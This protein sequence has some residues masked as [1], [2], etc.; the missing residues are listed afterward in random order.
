[1]STRLT[2]LSILREERETRS[3]VEAREALAAGRELK[4]SRTSSCRENER[5]SETAGSAK[6][7]RGK[8]TH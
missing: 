5:V 6:S 1:M 7:V 2:C 4:A 8:E 3:H